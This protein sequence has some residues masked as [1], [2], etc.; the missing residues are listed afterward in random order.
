MALLASGTAP[1]ALPGGQGMVH[2]DKPDG[3]PL[4]NDMPKFKERK[5]PKIKKH[6]FGPS[7]AGAAFRK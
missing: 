7:Q 4:A 6:A 5:P 2:S 3:A 1:L